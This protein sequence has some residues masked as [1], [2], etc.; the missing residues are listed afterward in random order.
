MITR[1]LSKALLLL[2]ISSVVPAVARPALAGVHSAQG[3]RH[4]HKHHER[5]REHQR[6]HEARERPRQPR[7]RAPRRALG[8]ARGPAR[9]PLRD[10]GAP[11]R[12]SPTS[13]R[14][15]PASRANQASRTF[16]SHVVER[17]GR[18]AAACAGCR[19]RRGGCPSRID[20]AICRHVADW[21][22]RRREWLQGPNA[23]SRGAAPSPGRRRS[24]ATLDADGG[25]PPSRLL[26]W[27]R[28]QWARKIGSTSVSKAGL[29]RRRRDTS[30]SPPRPAP[31]RRPGPGPEET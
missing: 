17:S 25:G 4:R 27:Q 6:E 9:P 23:L 18:R 28:V 1:T 7:R 21:S 5:R 8:C 14:S 31:A 20:P 2:T 13:S 10:R 3:R 29:G 12:V 22:S 15:G 11:D 26:S 19:P 24:P 30:S 16:I